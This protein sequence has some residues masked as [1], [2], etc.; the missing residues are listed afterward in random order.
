MNIKLSLRRPLL[1]VLIPILIVLAFVVLAACF[2]PK[3]A[4]PVRD[5]VIADARV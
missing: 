1:Y 4:P 5:A 2:I 3:I